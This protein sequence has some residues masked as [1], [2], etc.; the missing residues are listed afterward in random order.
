M[1]IPPVALLLLLGFGLLMAVCLTAWTATSLEAGLRDPTAGE[2]AAAGK[3]DNTKKRSGNRAANGSKERGSR[4]TNRAA[5]SLGTKRAKDSG[6]QATMTTKARTTNG[7][8]EPDRRSRTAREDSATETVRVR[9]KSRA[10]PSTEKQY[11]EDAFERF[12]RAGPD[13][14]DLR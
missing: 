14:T 12:L 8:V 13:D 3:E 11:E 1:D 10:A 7:I 5:G 2:R 6:S 4:T 9:E